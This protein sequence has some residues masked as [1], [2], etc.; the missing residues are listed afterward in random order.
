MTDLKCDV[1]TC[2]YNKEQLC[3][4]GDIMVGGKQ[5]TTPKETRCESF[6]DKEQDHFVSSLDHPTKSISIDCEAVNCKYNANYRCAAEHVNISGC[7][8]CGCKE[9]L[10]STFA[11]KT[12]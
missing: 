7:N 8:A 1:K 2:A 9:T 4:K 10:C 11:D 3:S 5:A 12:K 6:R